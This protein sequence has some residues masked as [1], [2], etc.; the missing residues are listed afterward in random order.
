MPFP[1]AAVGAI[2]TVGSAV[3]GY[4]SD[5]KQYKKSKQYQYDLFH[6]Y[7]LPGYE[8]SLIHI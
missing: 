8:L 4:F 7:T 6:K 2:A 5:K 1:W 3:S